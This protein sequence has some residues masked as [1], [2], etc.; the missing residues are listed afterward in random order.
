[1][2]THPLKTMLLTIGFLAVSMTIMLVLSMTDIFHTYYYGNLVEIYQ[3]VDMK[4][5]V[6]DGSDTRFF[7]TTPIQDGRLDEV[8]E[9][10]YP[11]FEYD[12]LIEVT[13]NDRSYA[14]V[15]ASS[16]DMLSHLS[17]DEMFDINLV[18]SD[19]EIV[20]TKSYAETHKV[21][22]GDTI[23]FKAGNQ[24]KD[25]YIKAVL[26]DGKLFSGESVFIDK[27]AS[28]SFFLTALD[29]ALASFPS[30]LLRNIYN[31]LYVDINE[32]VS[33][34]HAT[35]SFRE[36]TGYQEL[37]YDELI[38]DVKVND[39]V[40]R[41]TA[42][43]SGLLSFV[44]VAVML[45]LQTTIIYVF[46]DR[47]RQ[48]S[49]IKTLGGRQSYTLSIIG[50][51]LF[52][53]LVIAFVLAVL[54]MN[55]SLDFGM[56]YL[57]SAWI[58]QITINKVLWSLGIVLLIFITVFAFDFYVSKAKSD[59]NQLQMVEENKVLNWRTNVV[60]V[61]LSLS[62]YA[63]LYVPTF[64]T[65]LGNYTSVI[66][67]ILSVISLLFMA[68]VLFHGVVILTKRFR[69]KRKLYFHLRM[70]HGRKGF[71]H[72]FSVSLIVSLVVFLLIFMMQ[73]LEYNVEK[74]KQ[75][76][77][78]DLIV[79]R[80]MGNEDDIYH[81]ISMMDSVESVNRADIDESVQINNST[82]NVRFV[83]STDIY[84][85]DTYFNLTDLDQGVAML[86]QISEP[87]VLLPRAFEDVYGYQVDDEITMTLNQEN[88]DQ[89]FI[90]AGFF[91]KQGL[92]VAFTNLYMIDSDI[93]NQANSM[94]VKGNVERSILN[95][96]LLDRYSSQMVIVYD[97]WTQYLTPY[98]T[99][100]ERIEN[101]I[102]GYLSLL[103][104]CFIMTLA[105]HQTM[106]QLEREADDAR[107]FAV[108]YQVRDLQQTTVKVGGV[109]LGVVL[110]TSIMSYVLIIWQIEGMFAAFGAYEHVVF[111]PWSIMIG[112]CVNAVVFIIMWFFVIRRQMNP[113]LIDYIRQ[114]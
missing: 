41:N 20:I 104:V 86:H 69:E 82:S 22:V 93:E 15:Y 30:L 5:S 38:N 112:I 92:G 79:S 60:I 31:V 64:E 16:T 12:A 40:E 95:D 59:M 113:R 70:L 100:M 24:T 28:L 108:G 90:I 65:L 105:N 77:D 4:V 26:M 11:F 73:H 43:L 45:V 102:I 114:Y 1:M 89:I 99:S 97:F 80:M 10:I 39:L 62:V 6:N 8:A 74:T 103:M 109:I 75:E 14:R 27:Q 91:E 29:P 2:I 57:A 83:I 34:E 61:G 49:I 87:A 68:P 37:R 106:M 17:D 32:S 42:L 78:F 25:F 85:L 3:D 7:S 44:F 33:F 67:V 48:A 19:N 55:V 9:N 81:E 98:I 101:F 66:R 36:V 52:I 71:S 94:L 21:D 58:Y 35:E 84:A 13:E 88:P 107:M 54:L 111:N 23:T 96:Q 50:I 56:H 110:I 53:E 51:E 18:L 63:L 47:K 46:H 72:Y 76:Y